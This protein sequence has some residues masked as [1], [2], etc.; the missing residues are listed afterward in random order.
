MKPKLPNLVTILILTTITSIMWIG[1]GIYHSVTE[2][3]PASVSEEILRELTPTLD[4][5]AIEKIKSKTF[6]S[7]AEIPSTIITVATPSQTPIIT[8]SPDPS[9]TSSFET[10][11]A[12]PTSEGGVTP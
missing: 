3:A 7:P 9:S 8:P 11:V 12:T 6:V 2:E 10:P 5:A 1:L 4:K